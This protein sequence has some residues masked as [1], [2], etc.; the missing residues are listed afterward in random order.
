MPYKN[1]NVTVPSPIGDT[2]LFDIITGVLQGDTLS[3]YLFI[4]NLHYI[5]QTS[6]D[7]MRE[8]GLTVKKDKQIISHRNHYKCRLCR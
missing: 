2:Y 7:L 3:R 4:I 1:T 8:N 6:F 5:Q